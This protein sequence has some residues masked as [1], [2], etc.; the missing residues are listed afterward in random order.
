M[1][2][3]ALK[4]SGKYICTIICTTYILAM[5]KVYW[6]KAEV[7]LTNCVISNDTK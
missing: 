6:V 7:Y 4:L 5:S 2:D 1:E 3:I